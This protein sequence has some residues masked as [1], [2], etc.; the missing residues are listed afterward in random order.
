MVRP[1][2][3]YEAKYWSVKNT[4]QNMKVAKMGM[5]N[6]ICKHTKRDKI[7]NEVIRNKIEA[8]YM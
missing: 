8:T 6:W 7:R 2:L 3:L 1:N 4:L 5:L